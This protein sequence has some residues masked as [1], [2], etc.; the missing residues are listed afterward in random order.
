MYEQG[1]DFVDKSIEKRLS[2]EFD[3]KRRP[4][5]PEDA[6]VTDSPLPSKSH[7]SFR[8]VPWDDV[9]QFNRIRDIWF[10]FHKSSPRCLKTVRDLKVFSDHYQNTTSLDGEAGKH[11]RREDG[12]MKRL[13]Q[14]IAVAQGARAAGTHIHNG[15]QRDDLTIISDG[16]LTAKLLSRFL[17]E[18][19][20]IPCKQEDIEND[21]KKKVFTP[22]Q[23]PNTTEARDKLA[24]LKETLFPELK[25]EEF[26]AKHE[27]VSLIG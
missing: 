1:S 12:V 20:G 24:L 4:T 22:G 15:I 5:N 17:D 10:Q 16:K 13:R 7:L 23:V 18:V 14:Q 25:I 8:T 11:L 2:M 19:V 3:W 27:A 21:R 6:D 26:L 9:R